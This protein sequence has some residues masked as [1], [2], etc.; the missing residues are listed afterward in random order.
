MKP[1]FKIGDKVVSTRH[2]PH[3]VAEV[4]RVCAKLDSDCNVTGYTYDLKYT[5]DGYPTVQVGV[6]EDRIQHYQPKLF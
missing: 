3:V 6:K 2:E 5:Q 4:S 1:I